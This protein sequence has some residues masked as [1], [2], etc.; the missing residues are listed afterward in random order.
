MSAQPPIVQYW[1]SAEPPDHIVEL[2]RSFASLNPQ[3]PH[4]LFDALTAEEFIAAHFTERE[5]AA[6]RAC[7]PP[8]MQADYLR[9][10]AVFQL[11]GVWADAGFVCLRN[12]DPLLED[13]QSAQMFRAIRSESLVMNGFFAFTAPQHPFLRLA[14]DLSTE[15]IE[16]RWK[17][18]VLWITGPL[19]ITTIYRLHSAESMDAFLREAEEAERLTRAPG[20][21]RYARLLC[22]LIGS[23]D[24]AT[25]A[26]K[27][28]CVSP[29]KDRNK[30]VRSPERS[31]PHRSR[32]SHWSQMGSSIYVADA[33]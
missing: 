29:A 31:L 15:L 11:G 16:R 6:F 20:L 21:L 19:V 33:K 4:L 24:R 26:C 30:W 3:R 32:D 28:I 5:L 23:Q 27:G 25:T 22:E 17:G 9:Y 10:C 1:H 14:V 8:A 7:G 2:T 18:K 12:L 13:A